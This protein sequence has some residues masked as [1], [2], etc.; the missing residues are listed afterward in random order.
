M[1]GVEAFVNG[2]ADRI[3][4][5]ALFCEFEY[6]LAVHLESGEGIGLLDGRP[7]S[8]DARRFELATDGLTPS[9]EGDENDLARRIVDAAEAYLARPAARVR[10]QAPPS[11]R[12]LQRL[13]SLGYTGEE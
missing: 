4:G 2:D 8:R 12:Q 13:K 3:A 10:R 5:R 11:A 6:L 9:R 7:Y 1:V